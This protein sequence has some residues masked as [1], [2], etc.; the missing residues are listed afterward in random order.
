MQTARKKTILLIDDDSSIRKI[1]TAKF[2][3]HQSFT[4]QCATNGKE[5]LEKLHGFIP[6][7][8]LLDINDAKSGRI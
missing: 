6:D 1:Y 8:I 3:L 5:G 2:S 4:I 7:L